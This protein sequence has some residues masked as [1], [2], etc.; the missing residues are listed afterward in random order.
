MMVTEAVDR[1]SY[2]QLRLWKLIPELPFPDR[3]LSRYDYA[4]G[5]SGTTSAIMGIIIEEA[6]IGSIM[7]SFDLEEI[8][9]HYNPGYY[10]P[11]NQEEFRAM[12]AEG[13]RYLRTMIPSLSTGFPHYRCQY[14]TLT[15]VVDYHSYDHVVEIKS[16][17]PAPFHLHRT[18]VQGL[19]YCAILKCRYLTLAYPG[20]GYYLT[21]DLE[22]WNPYPLLHFLT[23]YS[24]L[25]K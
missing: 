13:S 8:I 4:S 24:D 11:I 20:Y 12:I 19:I 23:Q 15:G 17:Y 5:R 2:H 10:L 7:D 1:Y 18:A 21:F 9:A 3:Q 6:M 16:G 22:G 14:R 25:S